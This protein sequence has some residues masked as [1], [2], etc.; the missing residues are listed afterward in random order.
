M[1]VIRAGKCTAIIN[2]TAFSLGVLKTVS[3]SPNSIQL[4]Q[5]GG[6]YAQTDNVT[7]SLGLASVPA[8]SEAAVINNHCALAWVEAEFTPSGLK[9][10]VVLLGDVVLFPIA[11]SG[12][13]KNSGNT[14]I[15]TLTVNGIAYL[16]END[17]WKDDD[18]YF[19]TAAEAVAYIDSLTAGEEE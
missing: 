17:V 6:G 16:D 15:T 7:V 1:A 2:G 18:R 10:K 11:K 4:S 3:Y 5:L 8:A 13:A 9:H 12:V 19:D 14:T